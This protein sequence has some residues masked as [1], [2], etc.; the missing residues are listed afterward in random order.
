MPR[1]TD[2]KGDPPQ[3]PWT[4]NAR[5]YQDAVLS[6]AVPFEALTHALLGIVQLHRDAGCVYSKVVFG[7]PSDPDSIRVDVPEGDS[8]LVST[9]FIALTGFATYEQLT[10]VQVTAEP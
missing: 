10:A 6:I 4:Y 9:D 1:I 3:S 7:V 5:D 2:T 8:T